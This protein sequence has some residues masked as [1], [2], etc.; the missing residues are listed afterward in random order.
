MSIEKIGEE[1]NVQIKNDKRIIPASIVVPAGQ[2]PFPAV[3]MN[4]GHHGSK[5][6]GGGFLK[7][8]QAFS[9]EG[10]LSIRMDFPGCGESKEPFTENYISN[11]ISDSNT[12]LEYILNNYNIDKNRLGIFGYSL[13]GRVALSIGSNEKSPYK[14][15]G[16][17]APS[18]LTGEKVMINFFG[19]KDK[20]NKFK[21]EA[22]LDKGYADITNLFGRNET[23]SA[24]WFKDMKNSNPLKNIDKF[25]GNMLLLYGDKDSV[26]P[27]SENEEIV[28]AFPSVKRVIIENADHGYGFFHNQPLITKKVHD[29]FI[30]FFKENLKE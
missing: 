9:K 20:Y 10:I 5:E 1:V 13:G 16:L 17:L 12:S 24:N 11:M 21:E 29:S 8:A 30:D 26:I 4:H 19:G 22:I 14:A 3:V 27:P 18:V 6:E 15:M 25:K 2:G 23:L 7:I 28:S